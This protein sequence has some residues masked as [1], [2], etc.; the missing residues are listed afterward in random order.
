MASMIELTNL[1]KE[2]DDLAAV[3]NLTLT[4]SSGE[5]Y[6]LIGPN[7]AGKTT[8]I[9]MMCGLLEPTQGSVRIAGMDVLGNPEE[10]R[11]YI[12][13]LSDFFSVYD[14]LKVWEYLD[15]FAHAY[16]MP[17]SEILARVDE[18]IAQAGLEV[19]RDGMIRGLSRGMKQRLGI[20]RAMIHRPKVL[21]LDEPASGLDPKARIELRNLLRSARDEG[22]TIL[23]SSHILTEL[24][25][26]CTSIGV[27]EKG[28]L[29]RSGRLEEVMLAVTPL[30]TVR[31]QWLGD[32]RAQI[33][34]VLGRLACAAE[35]KLSERDGEFFFSGSD[36]ELSQVL[37]DLINGGVR[38][39]S[40]HEVKKTV[41]EMYMKVSSHE[42]M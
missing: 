23:I 20:A 19:K 37:A 34:A 38:I 21:V 3:E 15:Y 25:G 17:E 33:Q 9:R 6:G 32:G 29:V 1:R 10:A 5:I 22:A 8:T 39:V 26:F 41:E 4:I 16:K 7:G 13:Y 28:R 27:M 14:D 24:E 35:L 11:K 18:V 36:D 30:R 12:G 2:F 31:L 40:F 42:V